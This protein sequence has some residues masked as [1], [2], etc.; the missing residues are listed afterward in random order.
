MDAFF[1]IRILRKNLI[2]TYQF[3]FY[4]DFSIPYKSRKRM[5]RNEM[6][7]IIFHII[8][9][10]LLLAFRVNQLSLYPYIK[11][12]VHTR[13]MVLINCNLIKKRQYKCIFIQIMFVWKGQHKNKLSHIS[14]SLLFNYYHRFLLYTHTRVWYP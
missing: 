6:C 3:V 4:S 9:Y 13:T 14:L 12:L 5:I 2:C 8:P 1:P 10:E 11:R 7:D